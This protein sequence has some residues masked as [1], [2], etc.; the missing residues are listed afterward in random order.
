MHRTAIKLSCIVISSFILTACANNKDKS[1][2]YHWGKYSDTLQQGL[3][4]PP[5]LSVEQQISLIEKDIQDASQSNKPVPPSMHAHLALLL[6]KVNKLD[7]AAK[8]L[9]IEKQLFPESSAFIDSLLNRLTK[10]SKNTK[11]QPKKLKP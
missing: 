7:L 6:S 8:H 1:S 3:S 4:E 2:I 5:T 9:L 10:H 11:N